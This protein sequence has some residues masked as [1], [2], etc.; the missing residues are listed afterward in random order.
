[1]GL[2]PKVR[3]PRSEVKVRDT[4]GEMINGE[5]V[6]CASGRETDCAE[7][8]RLVFTFKGPPQVTPVTP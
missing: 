6:A 1:M 4:A 8:A 5:V 3:A 2:D 7:T